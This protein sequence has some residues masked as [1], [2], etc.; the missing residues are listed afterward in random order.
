LKNIKSRIQDIEGK[1]ANK[2]KIPIL[3]AEKNPDGTYNV[4]GK[5]YTQ[6]QLYILC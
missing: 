6:S 1:I 4:S 5:N 2:N 3:F